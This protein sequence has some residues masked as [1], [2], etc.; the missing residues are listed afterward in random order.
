M[1]GGILA[2]WQ[3]LKSMFGDSERLFK[4]RLEALGDLEKFPPS[5]KGGRPNYVAQT[6]WLAPFLVE[7]SE[8]ILLGESYKDI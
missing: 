5:L 4:F 8:I 2:A 6:A 1:T 7:V 3:S